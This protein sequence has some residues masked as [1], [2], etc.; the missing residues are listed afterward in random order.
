MTIADKIKEVNRGLK[1]SGN[2]LL[3]NLTN[4]ER[5]TSWNKGENPPPIYIQFGPVSYCNHKCVLCYVEGNMTGDR[6]SSE[7]YLRSIRE[8]AEFGVG[9]AVAALHAVRLMTVLLLIP[10]I[11]KFL[12]PLAGLNINK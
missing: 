9:A 1:L 8:M 2:K 7:V 5:I 6:L 11:V 3:G 4:L 12:V 10:T